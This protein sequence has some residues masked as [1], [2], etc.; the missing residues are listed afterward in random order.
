MIII[1]K[2]KDTLIIDDF[3]FMTNS[4]I[5]K[6]FPRNKFVYLPQG[7]LKTFFFFKY[8]NLLFLNTFK[9]SFQFPRSVHGRL[10]TIQF[11]SEHFSKI[12]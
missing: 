2:N 7:L 3:E 11:I 5:K 4:L 6:L 8:F 1:V 12:A 9:I 10:R